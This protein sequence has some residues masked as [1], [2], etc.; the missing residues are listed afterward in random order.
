MTKTIQGTIHGRTI[1][2]REDFGMK[3][4]QDVD[5]QVKPVTPERVW[6]D[7]IRRSAGCM[8]DDPNFDAVMEE[9]RRDRR[10]GSQ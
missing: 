7:G 10:G 5:A 4:G 1:E 3:D 6:G 8:V 9:V 2:L